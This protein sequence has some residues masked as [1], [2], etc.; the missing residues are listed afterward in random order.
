MYR[1]DFDP[2]VDNI[3]RKWVKSNPIFNK[4]LKK[5]VKELQEHPRLST[6][7]IGHCAETKK[8]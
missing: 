5:I 8:V 2:S 4:Q 7:A 3:I 6:I 1:I